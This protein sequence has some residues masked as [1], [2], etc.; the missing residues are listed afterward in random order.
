M[1]KLGLILAFLLAPFLAHASCGVVSSPIVSTST[2]L[3]STNIDRCEVGQKALQYNANLAK[4]AQIKADDMVKRGYF[5]HT[6]PEGK[7]IW[8]TVTLSGYTYKYAG[9]NLALWYSQDMVGINSAWLN[10]PTHKKNIV[11]PKYQD[12]GVGIAHGVD[13]LYVVVV[14]GS[15]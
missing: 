6:N 4:A 3:Y 1:Q 13:G 2:V 12:V 15:K 14:F 10:S 11:N 7:A 5:S 9:E 8:P